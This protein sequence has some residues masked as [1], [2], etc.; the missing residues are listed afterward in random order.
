[1]KNQL[2]ILLMFISTFNFY[3]QNSFEKGYFINNTGQ[4]TECLIKNIDWKDNPIDFK[5]KLLENEIVK[6]ETIE[7]VNEFGIYKKSK[8]KKFIVNIDLSSKNITDL[9]T[10]KNAV[11]EEKQL[12]L[13]VLIEGS[14]N[15]YFYDNNNLKSFFFKTE[16]SDIEQ[17]IY[18]RYKTNDNRIGYNKEYQEQLWLNLRCSSIPIGLI[19]NTAYAKKDLINLFVKYNE[20]QNSEFTIFENREKKDLFNLTFRPGIRNSSLSMTNNSS[21]LRNI[22]FGNT[23][24]YQA[25]FELE[26]LMPFNNNKWALILE[27]TIQSFKREIIFN[28]GTTDFN[29]EE[30]VIADY[31][32]VEMPFGLRHYFYL[33]K[34]SKIFINA[35]YVLDFN[36]GSKIN[37]QTLNDE[38]IRQSNYMALGIG[39]KYKDKYSLEYRYGLNRDLFSDYALWKS[40]YSKMSLIFGIKV[41]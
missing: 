26:Y 37:F 19:E 4:K 32:S 24:S 39:Y 2:L 5:Y 1:M 16:T 30:K 41:F 28:K 31:K 15:L 9:T 36:S 14:A 20:C 3:G 17:L 18:K 40:Q 23:L 34:D 11:F 7:S 38:E 35:S 6:T 25:G 8:Y 29:V 10:V 33:K 27:P 21:D 13:K 22:D 12:F